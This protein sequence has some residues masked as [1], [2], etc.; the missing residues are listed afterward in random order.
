[1][2]ILHT[3][4]LHRLFCPILIDIYAC[5]DQHIIVVNIVFLSHIKLFF[6][7]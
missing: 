1:V 3:I 7:P 4:I 6:V 2:L 5:E